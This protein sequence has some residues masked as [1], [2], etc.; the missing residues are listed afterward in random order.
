MSGIDRFQ[1]NVLH[2]RFPKGYVTQCKY[3]ECKQ[4]KLKT[5]PRAI[6]NGLSV[7]K[8]QSLKLKLLSTQW[9]E[10]MF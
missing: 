4:H 9:S 6:A 8:S 2:Y 1:N 7:C 5:A 10:R 3:K